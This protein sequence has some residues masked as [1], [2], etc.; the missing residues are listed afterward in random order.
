MNKE[1]AQTMPPTW[2][3][4]LGSVAIAFH[5][6]CALI[7]TLFMP[8]GPWPL[9]NGANSEVLAPQFAMTAG[10]LIAEP[11]QRLLKVN[12]HFR[13]PSIRQED[14]EVSFELI[15]RD[16]QGIVQARR[17][18]PDPEAPASI[19]YRQSVMAH[20][21]G[22]DIELPPPQGVVIPAPGQ[23]L[24][25]IRWWQPE[26]EQRLV[27]KQDDP[28][29]VPRNQLFRQPSPWQFIVAKSYSRFM[30]R[31]HPNSKIELVRTWYEP[32]HPMVLIEQSAPTADVL[33]RFHSSYGELSQ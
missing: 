24:P 6:L 10:T 13:F 26:G 20:Q 22:N 14:N 5:L 1:N 28:N 23:K 17:H 30:A 4:V 32:V 16:A 9:P 7:T 11:Y 29:A 3:M 2:V 25:T 15:V 21:L 19:R 12:Y 18:I 31:H 33:R 8:S 27:L